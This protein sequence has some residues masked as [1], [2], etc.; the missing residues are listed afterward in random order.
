[1]RRALVGTLL[2]A[3]L[4]LAGCGAK[5][6]PTLSVTAEQKGEGMVI[7]IATTNFQVGPDGHVHVRLN[8]GDEA[9]IY[10]NTYTIPKLEPGRYTVDV[11]LSNAKHENLG[12]KQSLQVEIKPN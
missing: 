7:H 4:L 1:V 12:V 6:A 8:G 2:F 10:A 11:E 5:P 3:I 9:M